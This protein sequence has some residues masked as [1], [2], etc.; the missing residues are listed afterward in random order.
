MQSLILHAKFEKNTIDNWKFSFK[1]CKILIENR[2]LLIAIFRWISKNSIWNSKNS[3]P[4]ENFQISK[5][6]FSYFNRNVMYFNCKF[7]NFNWKFPNFNWNLTKFK[8]CFRILTDYF[9]MKRFYFL[10]ILL[11]YR[12]YVN[13]FSFIDLILIFINIDIMFFFA[14][15]FSVFWRNL[16]DSA[17]CFLNWQTI[18]NAS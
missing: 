10:I 15:L 8:L 4:T 5:R 2:K 6:K 1:I 7:T 18:N 17:G 3:I 11:F 16:M 13:P 12:I 9:Q 14:A